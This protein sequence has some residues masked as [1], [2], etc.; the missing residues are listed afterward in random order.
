VS[1]VAVLGS[2]WIR[3]AVAIGLLTWLLAASQP[4]AV[5]RAMRGASVPLLAAAVALTLVDRALMAWRWLLLLY[6]LPHGQR[7]RLR[8]VMRI[9]FVSTFVGTFLPGAGGDIYRAYS[10]SRMG[11]S[12]VESAASVLMDRLLGVLSIVLVGVGA[13]LAARTLVRIP[14]MWMMLLAASAL[15][16]AAVLAVYSERVAALGQ[17][18]AAR[19]PYQKARRLGSGLIDAVRRYAHHHAEVTNVLVT[20]ILVQVIRVVQ[21]YCLGESL[22]L[23][24]P[25]WVYFAFVPTILLIMLLAPTV[26][27]L[28]TSQ[29]AFPWLFGAA[30]VAMDPAVALSI[31][32]VALGIVG[33]L[34]GALLYA[35]EGRGE[36]QPT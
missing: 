28:G 6:P 1:A 7:P 13:L 11:V 32:F 35:S 4:A 19:L 15:C 3:L 24:V 23:G 17:T 21:A 27:G 9:F 14:G 26:A 22:G 2:R 16:V 20:S 34:P 8:P 12:G 36:R 33:N 29:A 5:W 18:I 31:L 25:L 10:L 30:G